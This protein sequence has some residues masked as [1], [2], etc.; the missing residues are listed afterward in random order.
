[1]RNETEKKQVVKCKTAK[2]NSFERTSGRNER[3]IERMTQVLSIIGHFIENELVTRQTGQHF[4]AIDW[5][6]CQRLQS[7][8]CLGNYLAKIIE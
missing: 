3:V 5:G 4:G 7:T 8:V 2:V 6:Q 1:M